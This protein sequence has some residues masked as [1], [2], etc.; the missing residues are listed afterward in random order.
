MKII[1]QI[2]KY[3]LYAALIIFPLWFGIVYDALIFAIFIILLFLAGVSDTSNGKRRVYPS[4][5]KPAKIIF[6]FPLNSRFDDK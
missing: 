6:P 2:L 1:G 3:S 4:D 5:N